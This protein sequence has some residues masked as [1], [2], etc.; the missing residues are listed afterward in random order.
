MT[1]LAAAYR[2]HK[3][4]REAGVSLDLTLLERAERIGGVIKT[5]KGEGFLLEEGPDCFVSNKPWGVELCKELGIDGELIGTNPQHRRS[6]VAKDGTLYPVP[7]GVYLMIP[8]RFWPLVTTPLI[9]LRGKLRMAMDLFIPTKKDA[10]DETLESFVTRRLGKEAL[11]RLAQPMVGGIYAADPKRLS[12]KATMPQFLE[13]EQQ[14]GSLIRAMLKRRKEMGGSR[15]DEGTPSGPRY[16]LFV[17]FRNGLQ[18]LIDALVAELPPGSVQLGMQVE[19]VAFLPNRQ[20]WQVRTQGHEDLEADAVCIAVPAPAASTLLREL[21]SEIADLLSGISYTSSAIVNVIH[22]REDVGHP[23]DGMGFVVPAHENRSLMACSFSSV[24]FE[25]RAPEGHV[26]LRAF[27]GGE[28]HRAQYDLPDEKL[29]EATLKDLA[30]FLQISGQP[31]RVEI[32]RH[33]HAMAQY[34]TGHLER[35]EKIDRIAAEFPGFAL[36][37]NAYRGVGVP[38]CIRSGNQA[39]DTL[40][41][42]LQ[43]VSST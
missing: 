39:A 29:L 9:S 1:G 4:A 38:D 6:F 42:S 31:L 17:A 11:V 43:T 21:N 28:L 32:S 30:D 40:L 27:V 24:K 37:G 26:L 19:R 22:R 25:G 10:G 2:L 20:R 7:E 14:H 33:P 34:H 35:I 36:A 16:G 18:T 15:A 5:S 3:D 12:L 41:K 8:S 13:M 23:L